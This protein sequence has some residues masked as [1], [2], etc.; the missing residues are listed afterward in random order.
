MTDKAGSHLR[1]A[2]LYV[3]AILIGVS[4]GGYSALA[5]GGLLPGSRGLDSAGVDVNGWH[6]DFAIGSSSA[7]PYVRARVA[8]SGLLALSRSE[9][10]YFTT[11]SDED[12]QPLREQCDYRIFGAGMPAQWWS[13]TLYD[14]ESRLPMNDDH[15]LSIDAS[16][17]NGNSW[18]A[19]ISARRPGNGL[20]VSSRNAGRFDVTLR[21]YIPD[22]NLFSNPQDVLNP[23]RIE[24]LGCPRGAA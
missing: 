18:S 12:G 16:R 13:I 5:M 17:L 8:R 21:L 4:V 7:N 11:A 1:R 22:K 20:W 2:A 23:P 6:S 24:R 3:G 10:V 15:A 19:L 14:G 9:A